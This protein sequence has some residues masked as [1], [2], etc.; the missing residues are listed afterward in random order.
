MSVMVGECP[1][2]DEGNM[3]VRRTLSE[4]LNEG[5]LEKRLLKTGLLMEDVKRSTLC[6][7]YDPEA[8]T[9]RECRDRNRWRRDVLE[10]SIRIDLK[11][12][13]AISR[14]GAIVDGLQGA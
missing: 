7:E 9:C 4:L 13:R 3:N 8:E 12:S 14:L 5:N 11:L 6:S 1:V 2:Y 10:S